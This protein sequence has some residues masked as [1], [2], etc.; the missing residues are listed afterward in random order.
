MITYE[1]DCYIMN[2]RAQFNS[3][4]I[5]KEEKKHNLIKFEIEDTGVGIR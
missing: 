3:M 2:Q 1:D 5:I 4:Q